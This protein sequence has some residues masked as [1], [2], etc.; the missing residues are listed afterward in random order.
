MR[1]QPEFSSHSNRI[2][3]K[4]Y[5]PSSL[6]A[7]AVEL[8]VVTSTQWDSELIAHLAPKSA[9]LRESQV[10]WVGGLPAANQ[11]SLLSD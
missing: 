11:A 9:M 7:A 10:M 1:F 6:I 3:S 5:P 2:E 4:F 8:T